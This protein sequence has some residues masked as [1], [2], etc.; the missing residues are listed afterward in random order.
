MVLLRSRPLIGPSAHDVLDPVPPADLARAM[1]EGIGSL[2][3]DL[4]GDTA[5]VVLTL[6]RIRAT[7]ATG[8]I[9]SKDDAAEWALARL[10]AEHRPVLARARDV[11]LGLEED[12]WGDLAPRVGPHA[13]H[14]VGEIQ[15]I[16]GRS[17]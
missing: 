7:I 5:N 3:D 6:A 13:E 1:V 12:R 10:P 14:V 16:S 9:R 15:L 4:E 11:Y 8:E 2:L 17:P